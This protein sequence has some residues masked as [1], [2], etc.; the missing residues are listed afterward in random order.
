MEAKNILDS[1]PTN[2][3][4]DADDVIRL[5]GCILKE[6]KESKYTYGWV[7]FRPKKYGTDTLCK[8]MD[9]FKQKGYYTYYYE[10]FDGV[11]LGIQVY[12]Y[13]YQPSNRGLNHLVEY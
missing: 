1:I 2:T 13:H 3:N 5:A 11:W 10:R 7:N 12:N 6:L 4:N 9:I 8:V